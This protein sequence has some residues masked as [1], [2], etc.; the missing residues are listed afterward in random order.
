M[1]VKEGYIKP[2]R[3]DIDCLAIPPQVRPDPVSRPHASCIDKRDGPSRS[4]AFSLAAHSITA[5]NFCVPSRSDDWLRFALNTKRLLIFTC[6]ESLSG[7]TEVL[8]GPGTGPFFHVPS[9]ESKSLAFQN[10]MME[11]KIV[12][13][14]HSV[15]R[16]TQWRLEKKHHQ[17]APDSSPES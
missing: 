14:F 4:P 16:P 2:Q 5:K 10:K 13:A 15:N 9:T 3:F 11:V 12:L 6:V 7:R 1:S 17:S 8:L